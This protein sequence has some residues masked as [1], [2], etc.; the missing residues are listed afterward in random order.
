M[1]GLAILQPFTTHFSLW[2]KKQIARC[3]LILVGRRSIMQMRTEDNRM[4][5]YVIAQ[6]KVENR[7]LLDQYVTKVIPTIESH[8]RR[9]IAF[10]DEP[11]VVEGSMEHRRSVIVEFQSI[12][13]L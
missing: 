2:S 4:S 1:N 8:Q 9:L 10:D 11:D 7:G 13:A 6:G 12:L 5:I 3:N